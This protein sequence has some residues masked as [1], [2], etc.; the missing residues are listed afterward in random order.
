MDV[1]TL[2]GYRRGGATETFEATR[3]G[4]RK[5]GGVITLVMC[6]CGDEYRL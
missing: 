3:V 4:A 2:M 5:G 6:G 1:E